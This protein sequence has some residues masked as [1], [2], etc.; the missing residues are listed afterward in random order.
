MFD[1]VFAFG[2]SFV[3]GAELSAETIPDIRKTLIEK[4]GVKFDPDGRVH[5]M[6]N[7]K[8]LGDIF[9][10]VDKVAGE[11]FG[12]VFEADKGRVFVKKVADVLG[13]KY[14]NYAKPGAGMVQ[15]VHQ[16]I[17]NIETVRAAENPFVVVGITGKER[18]CQ[19]YNNGVRTILPYYQD[20][21]YTKSQRQDLETFNRLTLEYGDDSL[22]KLTHRTSHIFLIKHLLGDIPHV[23]TDPYGD[24]IDKKVFNLWHVDVYNRLGKKLSE[25]DARKD[26]A[27]QIRLITKDVIFPESL[28]RI[29]KDM[30]DNSR[31]LF[32]HPTEQVHRLLAD[33]VLA[34]L[35]NTYAK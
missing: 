21:L 33:Q 26:Y 24:S 18:N 15:I 13:S 2:D 19:F 9:A 34:Y 23:I 29:A 7:V 20:P 10:Y 6:D 12:D 31:C 16:L 25:T 17:S 8:N 11:T 4:F 32:W 22:S 14:Y 30:G 3:A 5:N 27:E 35:T 1:N 28:S